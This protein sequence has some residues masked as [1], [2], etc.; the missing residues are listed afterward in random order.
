MRE[1]TVDFP[2]LDPASMVTVWNTKII[3]IHQHLNGHHLATSNAL[4]L[5]QVYRWSSSHRQSLYEQVFLAHQETSD[6][7]DGGEST[8]C[9]TS[10]VFPVFASG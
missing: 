3:S 1:M 2:F 10:K 9:T 6:E 7:S 8:T 4:Q 5:D